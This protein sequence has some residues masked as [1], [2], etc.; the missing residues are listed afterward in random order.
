VMLV[1]MLSFAVAIFSGG[2]R[3][4]YM[5]SAATTVIVLIGSVMGEDA[6]FTDVFLTRL[7]LI[8]VATVYVVMALG[9]M[10][11]LRASPGSRVS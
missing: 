6:S 10:Q 5:G 4:A 1:V 3:A 2:S 8:A 9:L 7:L 11:R